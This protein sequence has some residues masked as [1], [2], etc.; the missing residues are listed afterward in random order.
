MSYFI[1][2][3]HNRWS[4]SDTVTSPLSDSYNIMKLL[5]NILHI[6][7]QLYNNSYTLTCSTMTLKAQCIK[8]MLSLF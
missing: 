5:F 8:K 6:Q 1:T 3:D 2:F 7:Q 4:K